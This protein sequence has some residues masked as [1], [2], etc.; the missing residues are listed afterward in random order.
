MLFATLSG[1]IIYSIWQQNKKLNQLKSKIIKSHLL[2]ESLT[3][4]IAKI[5]L[6][7]KKQDESL[8]KQ[9]ESLEKLKKETSRKFVSNEQTD[10]SL[11]GYERAKGL[12]Q[13]GIPLDQNMLQ[14]CNLT[15][16][17]LELLSDVT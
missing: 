17:E 14:K 13:R 8:K 6:S 16:E 2:I 9:D 3:T 5:D 10:N 7:L 12:V 1:F 11:H 15:E 4:K